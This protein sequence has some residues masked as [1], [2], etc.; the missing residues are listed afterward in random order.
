MSEYFQKFL[1]DML[2]DVNNILINY[3]MESANYFGENINKSE[4]FDDYTNIYEKQTIKNHLECY[5]QIRLLVFNKCLDKVKYTNIEAVQKMAGWKNEEFKQFVD[6][7]IK[8]L[9]V[10]YY[11]DDEYEIDYNSIIISYNIYKEFSK[12]GISDL[13]ELRRFIDFEMKKENEKDINTFL[14]LLEII[15]SACV[16]SPDWKKELTPDQLKFIDIYRTHVLYETP[17]VYFINET[18]K[19]QYTIEMNYACEYTNE[20]YNVIFQIYLMGNN[21][22]IK[23]SSLKNAILNDNDPKKYYDEFILKLWKWAQNEKGQSSIPSPKLKRFCCDV[24]KVVCDNNSY[25][26]YNS[27]DFRNVINGWR[28]LQKTNENI[29]QKRR[30]LKQD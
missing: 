15:D 5:N 21:K 26:R 6:F 3:P 14:E 28:I 2:S 13:A 9:F 7:I 4:L 30:T 12:D 17:V 19:P 1:H 20:F 11:D 16:G 25:V 29:L 27:Q 8:N 24:L 23:R 10:I 18:S 22:K